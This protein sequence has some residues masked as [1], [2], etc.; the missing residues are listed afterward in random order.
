LSSISY[1]TTGTTA[2]STPTVTYYYDEG[3]AAA[4]AMGRLTHFTD[5]PGSETYTYDGLGQTLSVAK[6]ISSVTYPTSYA[7]NL[8]G[9]LTSLTYPSGRVVQP[10]YDAAGRLSQLTSGGTSYV[11]SLQYNSASEPLS[12]TYGNGVQAAFSYNSRLQLAS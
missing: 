8:A 1:N 2:A 10:S 7:Y 5:G 4:N 9:E 12:F 6:A 11:S 3:G